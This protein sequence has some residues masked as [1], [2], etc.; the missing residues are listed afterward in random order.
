M[1]ALPLLGLAAVMLLPGRASATRPN[2]AEIVRLLG[3]HAEHAF[4]PG[5]GQ[6]G[7]LVA[8]PR[9]QTAA[10]LGLEEIAPGIGR[11]RANAAGLLAYADQHPGLS[12]EVSP[13]L[14]MLLDRS[15]TYV[16]SSIARANFHVDGTGVLVGVA[17]TGL[18]VNHPDM[19]DADGKTRVAWMI[20]L[21]KPPRGVWPELEAKYGV[22]NAT[23][24]LTNGAVF[25]ADDINAVLA[26]QLQAPHDE[27]GHGTHV[28]SIAAGNGG[29]TVYGGIAPNATLVIARVTRSAA[30]AIDNDD[31]LRGVSFIYDRADFLKQPVVVNLSLGGDYGPHDGTALWEKAL[32]SFVGPTH[33]GRALVVAAGNS[34]EILET[35]VHQSVRV[36]KGT[37]MRVPVNTHGATN[38]GVDIWVSMRGPAAVA[39]GLEGPDGE[40][41]APVSDGSQ[42][43]KN[44]SDYTSGVFNGQTSGTP[45]PADSHGGVVIWQGKWPSGTY[46]VTLTGEGTVDLFMQSSG[47]AA[48]SPR[49]A[50]FAGGV[51]EGTI[52]LPAT[53]PDI[54]AVGCTVNRT[55]WM[56]IT[57]VPVAIHV[58]LLDAVGGLQDPS[59]AT[60]ELEEGEVCWFSSAGPT[61]TGVPKPEISAPGGI[62]VAAMSNQARPGGV[63]SIFTTDGCPG[64]A[65][66]TPDPR[67][68]QIDA[69]HAVAVG[70]SMSAPMVAGAVALLFQRD[71][72]LTQD[73]IVALLQAGAHPFRGAAPFEDQGGP[74]ELDVL[75]SLDALDQMQN[76]ALHMP[77]PD[78][79]WVTLSADYAAADGS[80]PFTVIV[81]LRTELGNHRADMFDPAR[82]QP[83]ALIDGV[84]LTPAPTLVRHAP[85]VWFFDVAIPVGLGGSSLSVG[86][87]FDGQEIVARKT[88]PVGADIWTAD[89]PSHARGGCSCDLGDRT[90]SENAPVALGSAL[91][92]FAFFRQRSRRRN[93]PIS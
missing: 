65:G 20:D 36:T 71:P 70:T 38:G 52:N 90:R 68:F 93:L 42:R 19:L 75:G 72:T 46:N 23:G 35:P 4:A 49:P 86:A 10:A 87:A 22:K 6:I 58:P 41:V 92:A 73:K 43:G 47:D 16:H 3:P 26:V 66:T 40:W 27:V 21:S 11:I 18:D 79:S 82:L 9:G 59:K 13:P 77:S 15:A 53:H 63:G 50:G 33:P 76:P 48:S 32:A 81:E 14:H 74:G 12:M 89:Y 5:S 28:T 51:R 30:D 56:S 25:S 61:V 55:K 34:G 78:K 54:I 31:L 91:L 64:P 84:P 62:V 57:K 24:V 88:V 37:K 67:C 85:G 7:A 83:I 45:I 60:R 1:R 29:K 2:G 69:T 17:D 80:T 44:T 8:I 39:I